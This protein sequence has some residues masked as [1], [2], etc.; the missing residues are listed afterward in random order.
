ML[1]NPHGIKVALKY[2]LLRSHFRK[3]M[4]KAQRQ[5]SITKI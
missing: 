4:A 2:I 5:F 3:A 1:Q